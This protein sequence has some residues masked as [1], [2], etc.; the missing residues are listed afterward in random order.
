MKEKHYLFIFLKAPFQKIKGLLILRYEKVNS[1]QIT[2][3]NNITPFSVLSEAVFGRRNM[4]WFLAVL[5]VLAVVV[6]VVA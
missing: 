6:V 1:I 4:D 2:F 5:A 3:N